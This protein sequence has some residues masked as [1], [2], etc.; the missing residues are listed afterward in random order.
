MSKLY[1]VPTPIGN[2]GDITFRALEV[3]KS[4]DF[5]AAEDTR[6][7]RKLL[8]HFEIKSRLISYH[9][10]NEDK[11]ASNI[12]NLLADGKTIALVSDAGT[13]AVSDPGHLIVRMAKMRGFEVI[14]LPGASALP[15]A[16]S[17]S[18]VDSRNFAFY[19]FLPSK[20]SDMK[21]R[22]AEIIKNPISTFVLYESPRRI[23]RLLSELADIAPTAE[24]N[25]L[26][27]LTKMYEKTYWGKP[28]D[29]LAQL[30]ENPKFER[31]E[32]TLVVSLHGAST[33]ESGARAGAGAN[34]ATGAGGASVAG[35]AG[36]DGAAKAFPAE[37]ALLANYIKCGNMKEAVKTTATELGASKKEIYS[38]SI[39]FWDKVRDKYF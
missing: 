38:L 9:K 12:I 3:L 39:D 11:S 37:A 16:V 7:T 14:G 5:I 29:V 27:D 36:A 31:G 30:L 17:V 21:K 35:A 10:F 33:D 18:G 13:P 24:V 22:L 8:S 32:Y 23:E 34:V 15:L 20:K 25:L 6:V 2:L 28:A 26:N 1:I 19:G 4:A